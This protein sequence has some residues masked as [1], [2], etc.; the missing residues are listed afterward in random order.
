MMRVEPKANELQFIDST[1]GLGATGNRPE[2]RK[3]TRKRMAMLLTALPRVRPRKKGGGLA[4]L[5]Y[6]PTALRWYSRQLMQ[7]RYDT[8]RPELPIVWMLMKAAVEPRG[9]RAS[10]HAM[11]QVR[12]TALMGMFLVGDTCRFD[13]LALLCLDARPGGCQAG[14]YLT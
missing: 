10:P 14:R 2:T 6:K 4:R 5:P 12:N 7:I 11:S 8:I 3:Q 9:I 13:V 1:V